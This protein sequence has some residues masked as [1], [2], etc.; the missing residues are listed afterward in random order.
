MRSSILAAL[1]FVLLT[2]P[3]A[4]QNLDAERAHC[5]NQ[6]DAYGLDLQIAGCTAVIDSGRLTSEGLGVAL[7]RRA[8]AYYLQ[9][10]YG[11]AVVDYDQLLGRSPDDAIALS[12]R[13]LAYLGQRDFDHAI[14]D[15]DRAA[16]LNPSEETWQYLRCS[17]RAQGA[18]D[19]D[20]ARA[21]C[22]AAIERA[23][24]RLRFMYYRTRGLVGLRQ[25]RWQDAWD[26]YDEASRGGILEQAPGLFGRGI[27]AL[28][29][30][31]TSEG[32]ADIAR[33]TQLRSGVAQTFSEYGIVP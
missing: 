18:R 33:A 20:V 6:N 9:H 10:N 27:A 28:R 5:D 13:G 12:L 25:E 17:A 16:I 11:L 24:G 15:F 21:A 32:Q 1:G 29:L 2:L 14:R 31:R 8:H 3:A 26:D 23:R 4:A 7:N 30:G 19:L 22:D